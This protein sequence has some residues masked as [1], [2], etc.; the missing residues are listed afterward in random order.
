MQAKLAAEAEERAAHRDTIRDDDSRFVTNTFVRALNC[1]TILHG[2]D[3]ERMIMD[4]T[5]IE[6]RSR[7]QSRQP[8]PRYEDEHLPDSDFG[9]GTGPEKKFESNHSVKT[10]RK[11]KAQT[12]A[13]LLL[14]RLCRNQVSEDTPANT[15][16][17]DIAKRIEHACI[18]FWLAMLDHDIGDSEHING[19]ISALMVLAIDERN[20]GWKPAT[21]YTPILSAVITVS[22]S[23][24]VYKAYDNRNAIV[25]R[26]MRA[27]LMSEAR[28]RQAAPSIFDQVQEMSNKFIMLADKDHKPTPMDWMLHIRTLG[29]RIRYTTNAPGTV[30]WQ[31]NEIT[32]GQASFRLADLRSTVQGLYNSTR[33]QLFQKVIMLDVD[34]HGRPRSGSG[35]GSQL[36]ELNMDDIKDN[37]SD[38]WSDKSNFLEYAIN[39]WSVDGKNW[40]LDRVM[41]DDKLIKQFDKIEAEEERADA[42]LHIDDASDNRD[43]DP[44]DPDNGT[45]SNDNSEDFVEEGESAEDDT[46]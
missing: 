3:R 11:Y 46:P 35:S 28:A 16:Q 36:P 20:K 10:V 32:I 17:E 39:K 43:Y 38:T 18:A 8:R 25:K 23:M 2:Q 24:V 19:M 4:R 12:D 14:K 21:L 5:P 6:A 44:N 29:M 26:L 13:L 22:R 40:L 41:E 9:G 27:E 45:D 15:Q 30:E 42:D 34:D 31:G 37:P 1:A 7:H 33:I